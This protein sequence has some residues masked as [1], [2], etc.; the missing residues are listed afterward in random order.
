M[1][2]APLGPLAQVQT[3]LPLALHRRRHVEHRMAQLMTR[4]AA[5]QIGTVAQ[6]P[7]VEADHHLVGLVGVVL[8]H[9]HHLPAVLIVHGS[10]D[11]P[12]H[13]EGDTVDHQPAGAIDRSP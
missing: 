11:V 7:P 4:G 9:A 13:I 8:A 10:R 6:D 3:Q 2:G 12:D 1:P 5:Q